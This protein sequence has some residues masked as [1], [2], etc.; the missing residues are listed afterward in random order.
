MKSRY[1]VMVIWYGTVYAS[2]GVSPET[3][4]IFHDP[5]LIV[6]SMTNSVVV[7]TD[8][9]ADDSFNTMVSRDQNGNFTARNIRANL[10]GNALTA[11]HA[12]TF[13][14]AL[15]GDVTGKQGA[16]VVQVVG[17]QSAANIAT[18]VIAVNNAMVD[19]AELAT[20]NY[21][22]T[23]VSTAVSGVVIPQS[24][25]TCEYVDTTVSTAVTGLA[26]TEQLAT[27]TQ[28]VATK[29]YVNTAISRV[30]SNT[31]AQLSDAIATATQGMAT[32]QYV[33][34]AV[35]TAV[36]DTATQLSGAIATATHNMA[37]E[38]YVDTAVSN[39][40]S[41]TAKQVT[42]A[43]MALKQAATVDTPNTLVM[44]NKNG[45]FAA[46]SITANLIGNATSAT[47]A[48]T[49]T[50]PLAGDVVGTQN[51]TIVTKVGQQPASDIAA[52]AVAIQ[53]ATPAGNGDTLVLRDP[54]GNCTMQMMTIKGTVTNPTDVT[55]KSY[56]DTAVS[57]A[58]TGF[59]TAEHLAKAT[60]G[61]ATEQYVDTAVSNATSQTAKQMADV[62]ARVQQATAA[63]TANTLVM[64]NKHGGFVAGIVTANLVGNAT[65]AT[66][67][68]TF[69]KPLAG[70]VVGAHNATIVTKVGQQPA[71][72]IAAAVVAI[73]RA[74][75]HGNGDTLVLRDPL[76]NCTMQM[77]T[78][79]GVVTNPTDVTTKQYVDTVV[80]TAVSGIVVP[81]NTVTKE[82]VDTAVS[83]AVTGF[84]TTEHLT[85]ALTAATQ[86]A[87][88]K[89][90]V[91]TAVSSVV[92][93]T[94]EHLATAT[95]DMATK[96]YV[97]TAVTSA[98]AATLQSF[99]T[100]A[101][102]AAPAA[103]ALT[104]RGGQNIR[105]RG[106]G[107]YVVVSLNNSPSVSGSLS[108]GT[109]ITAGTGLN[110]VSGGAT[111][112]GETKI[113]I[114]GSATTT[115]G[116]TSSATVLNGTVRLPDIPQG[117]GVPLVIDSEGNIAI[118]SSRTRCADAAVYEQL[119]HDL[120][121][122]YPD[123]LASY[124]RTQSDEITMLTLVR[125]LIAIVDEQQKNRAII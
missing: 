31:A 17:G 9:T 83:A 13:N 35:T 38:Q 24:G 122:R 65:S 49:F 87:V 25:V 99:P 23:A 4:I 109:T 100:D 45:G 69:T 47:C 82:Y 77:I 85:T 103:G 34:N 105:T 93:Q 61:V 43:T 3:A 86:D 58:V 22:D 15:A 36:S 1:I 78:V 57:A 67:A 123:V 91:D 107:S 125:A 84:A 33:N 79:K 14:Q 121:V 114:A 94:A 95:A 108:A 66:C 124:T 89:N 115:I 92:S 119:L 55:T 113:N 76:G 37:T 117:H 59:A 72:N 88:T 64:R 63:D 60:Q 30:V 10:I 102:Y 120:I 46:S 116:N 20:K 5:H 44:R 50:K 32:E 70:D 101:G 80:S 18:A 74:T 12:N 26:T 21:V 39:T 42:D 73:Q 11:T 106:A 53:R 27:A 52:A 51:A 2:T 28:G 48:Q 8:A 110:V 75:P 41:Q 96:S 40:A 90:Y 81:Q 71:S 62:S 56:V 112:M 7:S 118:A 104:I 97:D 111:I 98:T 6:T 54:L 19:N 29:Q 16:T 68:Q